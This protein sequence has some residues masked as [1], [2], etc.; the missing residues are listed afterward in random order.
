M[1]QGVIGKKTNFVYK[2]AIMVTIDQIS[3]STILY[4]LGQ[5]KLIQLHPNETLLVFQI[6]IL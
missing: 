4:Y 6:E 2:M 1:P 5:A 3:N